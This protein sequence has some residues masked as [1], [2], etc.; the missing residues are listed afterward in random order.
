MTILRNDETTYFTI[1]EEGIRLK[2]GKKS[3]YN[4]LN[5]AYLH[6]FVRSDS[7]A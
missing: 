3:V 5:F 4:S 1:P 2:I 6:R 7:Q